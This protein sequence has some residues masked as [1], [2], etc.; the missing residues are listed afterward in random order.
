M[1][2]LVVELVSAGRPNCMGLMDVP[3]RGD[4]S[5]DIEGKGV[6]VVVMVQVGTFIGEVKGRV[7]SGT[8]TIVGSLVMDF[9]Y[10]GTGS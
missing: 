5:V 9:R 3:C 10:L 7:D 4:S 1:M 8:E 2:L 6:T